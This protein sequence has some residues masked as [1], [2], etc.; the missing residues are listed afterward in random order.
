MTNNGS[1]PSGSNP[2]LS[3]L[4]P[5]PADFYN[6]TVDIPLDSEEDLNKKEK[7]LLAKE[8]DLRKREKAL[9]RKED[10]AKRAGIVIEEKNWPPCLPIIHHDIGNEI[11]I[12]LQRLC[13]TAFATLLGLVLCLTWNILAATLQLWFKK[14]QVSDW[15]LVLI[16]FITGVPCAYV[17]WYRPLYRAFRNDSAFNFGRFFLFYLVHICFVVF[18]AVGPSIFSAARPLTGILPAMQLIGKA[19]NPLLVVFYFIGFGLYCAEALVSIWVMQQ[20]Y[21][22]FRGGGKAEQMRQGAARGAIR[23]AS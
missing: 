7:E 3:P 4:P 23:A 8:A 1:R 16:Y 17:L 9:K 18:A 10:A 11:P 13:Y 15:F 20:V 19:I 14:N 12:H 5:E 22:Y 2:K 6:P 21:T